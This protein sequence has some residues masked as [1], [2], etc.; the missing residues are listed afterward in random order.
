M[1]MSFIASLNTPEAR[2][3]LRR[4]GGVNPRFAR[5]E[6]MEGVDPPASTAIVLPVAEPV[7][8]PADD[9]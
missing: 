2:Q 3:A 1:A 5:P 9:R 8:E 4:I 6:F 7:E